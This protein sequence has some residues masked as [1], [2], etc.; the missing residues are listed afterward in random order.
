MRAKACRLGYRTGAMAFLVGD[1]LAVCRYPGIPEN[2]PG[3][4][5]PYPWRRSSP[6]ISAR[7]REGAENTIMQRTTEAPEGRYRDTAR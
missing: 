4:V 7:W 5:T 1:A 2:L 6:L 3:S